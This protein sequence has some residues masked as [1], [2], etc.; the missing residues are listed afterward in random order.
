LERLNKDKIF[1]LWSLVI[2]SQGKSKYK[3]DL[4]ELYFYKGD[5]KGDN[6]KSVTF[7]EYYNQENAIKIWCGPH[8]DFKDMASTLLHEYK[9]HLQFWPWYTRYKSMYSYDKNPYEIEAK[10]A[11]SLAPDLVR[12]L[13][14]DQWNKLLKK[15]L[16]LKRLY[17]RSR[18][19]VR[20]SE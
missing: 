7:G 14:D 1:R 6:Q 11:E 19:T 3:K 20:V 2:R 13:S 8:L 16:K 4:P 17:E 12:M 10:E 15:D 5:N 9:H 18:N